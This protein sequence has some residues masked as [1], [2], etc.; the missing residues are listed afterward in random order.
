MATAITVPAEAGKTWLG[1]PRGLFLLFFAEMWERFSYYGMRAILIFYLTKHFLFGDDR[2]YLLYGAYTSLVYITPVIGGYLSDRFL[3]PRKAVL[4]G[5]LFIAIGHFLIAITEGPGGQDGFY[6]NGFYLALASIIVGT[7]FLKAN[8]SVL[9]G[10]LY[11]RDDHRRD[12]AFTIFYM[13]INVGGMM[14]PL[15]C[16]ALGEIW[17]WSWGFGAAGVGMLLGLVM[18][19]WLRPWLLGKGEPPAPAKLRAPA[20]GALSQEWTIYVGAALGVVAIWMVIRYAELLG[21]TL[22][23]FSAMT[24]AYILWRTVGTLGKIDRDRMFA[25]LFLIS[26]NPLF[27]GLFEQTGSSLN[28]FTDRNVDRSVLGWDIPASMFQSVNSIFIILLAPLFA[29]LWPLLDKRRLEPS[30]PAKFGIGLVLCGAGFLVLVAGAAMAGANL[31]PLIFI[32]LIYLL[33]TMAELCFS[34]V[35]LSAMTR[36]SVPNMVGLVMGTWFLAMAAGNFIAGLIARATGGGKAGDVTQVLDVYSRIGW[37]SVVVGGL[38]LLVSP[39]VKRMMHLDL[40][41]AEKG[42]QA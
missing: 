7:G 34:P 30:S 38:V 29:M 4:V 25:A 17:G 28:I 32:L 10:E 39:Y 2:A 16:G 1:H 31:T 15:V 5:G 11:P 26:L 6:L 13:G 23:I 21:Y 40:I 42:K 27:W 33:H 14:G 24:V 36:L 20:I 22:L 35:G 37:F 12:P 18:F 9:V 3:G 8:I 19:V 41:A